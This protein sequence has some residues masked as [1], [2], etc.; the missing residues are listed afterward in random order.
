[1]SSEINHKEQGNC[2]F[3]DSQ[4]ITWSFSVDQTMALSYMDS[5]VFD[6]MP[7]KSGFTKYLHRFGG[8][9]DVLPFY[10]ERVF[11]YLYCEMEH[12]GFIH[13]QSESATTYGYPIVCSSV[14][15]GTGTITYPNM[16]TSMVSR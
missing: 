2:A 13:L 7:K 4:V 1:M 9:V 8:G 12:S 14:I 6:W 11:K 5:H 10:V 15:K 3:I 16:R